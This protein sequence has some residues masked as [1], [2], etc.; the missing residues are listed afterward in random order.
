ML[1]DSYSHCFSAVHLPLVTSRPTPPAGTA[2][3][4]DFDTKRAH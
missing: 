3:E 1:H 2:G 4:R